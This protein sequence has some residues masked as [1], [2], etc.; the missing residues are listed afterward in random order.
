MDLRSTPVQ[1]RERVR[2][3]DPRLAPQN[4][5]RA[6][7]TCAPQFHLY[8]RARS[9]RVP[10]DA[11]AVAPVP[12]A[13]QYD[14][15]M[16][17]WSPFRDTPEIPIVRPRT[18]L[19]MMRKMLTSNPAAGLSKAAS[20]HTRLLFPETVSR[21]SQTRCVRTGPAR[22]HEFECAADCMLLGIAGQAWES[23]YSGVN[24]KKLV[25]TLSRP[26]KL[27]VLIPFKVCWRLTRRPHTRRPQRAKIPRR[28]SLFCFAESVMHL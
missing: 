3:P 20:P 16:E 19:M 1:Q 28:I 8:L 7:A 24:Q 6:R 25:K 15:N 4:A 11:Q 5:K 26:Q 12:W 2:S 27:E 9:C 14:A 13:C 10:R 22:A 21:F 18:A 23:E 17:T